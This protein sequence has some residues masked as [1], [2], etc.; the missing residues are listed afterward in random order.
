MPAAG[1]IPCP[2]LQRF[3]VSEWYQRV[4]ASASA[5]R[6]HESARGGSRGQRQGHRPPPQELTEDVQGTTLTLP[7]ACF[8]WLTGF[9]FVTTGP[10]SRRGAARA[11]SAAKASASPP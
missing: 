11:D 1:R 10:D 3:P 6:V 2:S 7:A 8:P 4:D 9:Q 5:F